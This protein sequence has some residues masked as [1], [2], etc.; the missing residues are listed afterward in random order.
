M[1]F[2]YN[3]FSVI[4]QQFFN[5]LF[6]LVYHMLINSQSYINYDILIFIVTAFVEAE[7]K[8]SDFGFYKRR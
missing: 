1:Y 3:K 2:I 8:S 6:L 5:N 7:I 4:L